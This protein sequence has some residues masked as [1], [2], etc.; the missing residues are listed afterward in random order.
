M[1]NIYDLF[2]TVQFFIA[3]AILLYKLY[4]IMSECDIYDMRVSFILFIGY[5]LSYGIGAI[6][7]M[8]HYSQFGEVTLLYHI[9]WTLEGW[10]VLVNVLFLAIEII[11]NFKTIGR[12][13]D[14]HRSN[15]EN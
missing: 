8:L 3:I 11:F 4:N 10:L 15:R 14:A 6:V 1:S 5:F 7:V 12:I 2:F 13:T 9:L